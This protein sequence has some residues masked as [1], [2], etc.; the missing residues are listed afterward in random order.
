MTDPEGN[1]TYYHYTSTSHGLPDYV[2]LGY[3]SA[4]ATRTN[5]AYDSRD[6]LYTVETDGMD[7][8]TTYDHDALDR[9]TAVTGP[10]P[11][12]TGV[13]HPLTPSQ[14]YYQYDA[15]SNLI[16]VI[17]PLGKVTHSIYDQ[18]NQLLQT[19]QPGGR[20]RGRD[21]ILKFGLRHVL[22]EV[23][24]RRCAFFIAPRASYRANSI[25]PFRA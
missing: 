6:N 24:K 23:Q 8:Q 19:I 13:G 22:G 11:D 15:N 3:G 16:A 5:Y 10:D 17:D 9:L 7:D 21:S 1:E 4:D 12:G 18:R 2:V 14:T 25:P 20:K